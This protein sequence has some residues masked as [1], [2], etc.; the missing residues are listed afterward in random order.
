MTTKKILD[1]TLII[2]S[3]LL[4]IIIFIGVFYSNLALFFTET[5]WFS[6]SSVLE[7]IYYIAGCAGIILII[8][9]VRDMNESKKDA[10]DRRNREIAQ[11]TIKVCTKFLDLLG[12]LENSCLLNSELWKTYN[13]D[14]LSFFPNELDDENKFKSDYE[15]CVNPEIEENSILTLNKI[16][17]FAINFTLG[18]L[19]TNIMTQLLSETL[20][21]SI[22]H[23]KPYIINLRFTNESS[24]KEIESLYRNLKRP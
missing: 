7:N 10:E 16:E 15:S 3:L 18:Y 4:C 20:I 1:Y 19:N 9:T 6:S 21:Q 14:T 11:Q 17:A 8:R 12:E 2:L 5:Q 22:N 24:Y 13:L 23:L